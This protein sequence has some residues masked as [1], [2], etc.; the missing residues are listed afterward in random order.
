MDVQRYRL[1]E[2]FYEVGPSTVFRGENLVLG[3]HVLIRRL[4][5]EADRAQD[6]R[7][8]FFREQRHVASLQHPRILATLDAFEDQGHLWSVHPFEPCRPTTALLAQ[9]GPFHLTDATR[10]ASQVADGLAYLHGRRFVHGRL[11]PSNVLI[12]ERGDVH[13]TTFVKSAD[14]AAGIWPLRDSV[15]G[16]SEFSAP[17]EAAGEP[18]TAR[19]DLF[20]LAACFLYWVHGSD[21]SCEW[22]AATT[23]D[24][25]FRDDCV[26]RLST[27]LPELPAAV[28]D[29][30][31]G[32]LE[33]DPERRRGSVASFASVLLEQR[34]RLLAETPSGFES[35]VALDSPGVGEPVVLQSRIGAGRHGVVFRASRPSGGADVA[36]KVLKAEFRDDALSRERFVREAQSLAAIDHPNVVS[37]HG[38]GNLRG[39][40]FV[41]MDH[42]DGP[43]LG[44]LLLQQGTLAPAR[45]VELARD[46]FRGLAAIHREGLLHRDL[47]PQNV[48]LVGRG[49]PVIMDLGVAKA[50]HEDR[51]TITGALVGTPL[52]MSPEQAR[53]RDIGPASDVYAMGAVLYEALAGRPPHEADDL[54]TLLRALWDTEPDPL[55]SDVPAP[56]ADLVH[57]LLTKD[58]ARRPRDAAKI[59]DRF[60]SLLSEGS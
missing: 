39:M 28:V 31:C 38:V 11:S 30:L 60:E 55:P 14:L 54:M 47:K 10:V 43:D 13:L 26:A 18:T 48:I 53:G 5:V 16:V 23:R 57:E 49:R 34:T 59:A 33:P 1:K 41:V 51:L 56:L 46:L 52:Y 29:A 44:A 21:E 8:T 42:L 25:R 6:Q 2:V 35:G 37:V 17:E 20:S 4:E 7:E 12:D 32:A 58:P 15:A 9:R 36:V 19:S 22:L 3:N 40:P 50:L 45:V 24:E 27:R